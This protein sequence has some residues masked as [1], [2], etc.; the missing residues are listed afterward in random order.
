MCSASPECTP[1]RWTRWLL[2]VLLAPAWAWAAA[3]AGG[4]PAAELPA[5]RGEYEAWLVTVAPGELYWQ[6]FG[7]NAIWIREPAEG[8]DHTFNFGY[9]DFEQEDFLRRFLNG[10]MLY[11]SLAFPARE[12]LT[13]YAAEQRSIRGQ[14]LELSRTQYL[15]LRN[16]LLWH[17]QPANRDYLY[18][19]YLDNC[20]TRVRDA[21]DLALDGKLSEHFRAQPAPLNF[22][23]HTRRLTAMDYWYYLGLELLLGRPV[24]RP[25]SRWDEMFIPAVLADSLSQA[26]PAPFL[27]TLV[28]Q[29]TS[30]YG[31][32]RSPPSA[33]PPSVWPRYLLLSTVLVLVSWWV[34]RRR[35]AVPRSL[36][37][38]WFGLSA[39][40]GS[41]LVGMWALTDH[42][43]IGPNA[44]LLLLNPLFAGML[45]QRG[46][47]PG[48]ALVALAG[49]AALG[50]GLWPGGQFNLD[51][52]AALLPLNL[53]AAWCLTRTPVRA[54]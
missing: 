10:R 24:D 44:N 47:Q 22:R 20:S 26:S 18:D 45:L 41:V 34:G 12:E 25:I 8:L 31:A 40:L 53:A 48:G 6:R 37:R 33:L 54:E 7:H 21:I 52:V 5:V 28:A 19:Y 43:V 9:F 50:Q 13:G 16:H 15:R 36:A 29:D 2:C 35:E 32:P 23:D 1:R 3:S 42:L 30:I 51:V 39:L 17:V 11:Q 49:I 38:A 46:L 14:R 4:E 27:A